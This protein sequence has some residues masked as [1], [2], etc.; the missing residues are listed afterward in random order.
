MCGKDLRRVK[1]ELE[2]KII[3]RIGEFKYL[4]HLIL[5]IFTFIFMSRSFL[6]YK[7]YTNIEVGKYKK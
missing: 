3:E 6:I 4:G 5:E 1:I 2:R 7:N